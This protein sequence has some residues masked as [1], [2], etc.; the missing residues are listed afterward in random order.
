M[1]VTGGIMFKLLKRISPTAPLR[2]K[3]WAWIKEKIKRGE[4]TEH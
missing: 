4:S 3:G 2:V 1:Q